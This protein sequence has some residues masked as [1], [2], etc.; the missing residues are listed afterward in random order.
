[1][2]QLF[3]RQSEVPTR[4]IE[5]IAQEVQERRT[6][7][8]NLFA[9]QKL[10]VLGG[11]GHGK[12]SLI[13]TFNH[14]IRLAD[15]NVVYEEVAEVGPSQ[16]VTKTP[17][18]NRYKKEDSALFL[19]V[20]GSNFPVF[21]DTAG[22]NEDDKVQ[23]KIVQLVK[24]LAAGK[25]Q[26]RADTKALLADFKTNFDKMEAD[27]DMAAWTIIFVASAAYESLLA[28]ARSVGEAVDQTT[29]HANGE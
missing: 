3:S 13:N 18:L 9:G 12:S 24:A 27:E 5:D 29:R 6:E 8:T 21:L 25:I 7:V 26:Q 22:M 19:G 10:L 17:Y 4:S 15:P 1:M 11:D 2:G 20:Q 28:L 16:S 23:A 14:V